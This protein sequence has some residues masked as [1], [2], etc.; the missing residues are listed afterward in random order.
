MISF[1]KLFKR[2]QSLWNMLSKKGKKQDK[3]V[4]YLLL[5][6]VFVIILILGIEREGELAVAL[7]TISMALAIVYVEIIKPS[8][9]KP[10]IKMEFDNRYPF[11]VPVVAILSIF[12]KRIEKHRYHIRIR[13]RNNGGAI[14]NLRAKLVEIMDKDGNAY[15]RFDPVFLHWVAVEFTQDNPRYLDPITLSHGEYDYLD[16]VFTERARKDRVDICTTE[17]QRGAVKSFGMA[18]GIS[19]LRIIIYGE[20]ISPETR[21]Y[22]LVWD[23]VIYDEIKMY[24]TE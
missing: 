24:K 10:E 14:R 16:V 17:F 23:G 19:K 5:I 2:L 7:G 9:G 11:C 6:E 22:S 15:E 12:P 1:Q 13:I 18:Q 4:I 3:V 8:L 20:D 21:V